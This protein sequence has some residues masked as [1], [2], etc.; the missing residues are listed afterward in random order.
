MVLSPNQNQKII[1]PIEESPTVAQEL[2]ENIV[3][4]TVDDL[5]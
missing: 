4:T 5:Y 2:S 3:L 1:N